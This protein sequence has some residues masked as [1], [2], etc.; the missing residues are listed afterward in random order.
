MALARSNRRLNYALRF[1]SP[2]CRND[3]NPYS[4]SS[5]AIDHQLD[6]VIGDEGDERP[7]LPAAE[8]SPAETLVADNFIR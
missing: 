2:L 1:L 6:V 4:S 8:L 3:V 5:A 7:S